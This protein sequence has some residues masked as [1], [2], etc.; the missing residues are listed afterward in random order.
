MRRARQTAATKWPVCCREV[1]PVSCAAY[2]NFPGLESA[3]PFVASGS[4]DGTVYL[5]A[6]PTRLEIQSHRMTN[7]RLRLVT[8][9]QDA[10]GQIR[11]G[12]EVLNPITPEHRNGR[13]RPGQPVSIAFE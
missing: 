10:S 8:N 12:V 5:W 7:A 3:A 6:L 13:F 9:S 2:S 11:V 4:Q 1:A